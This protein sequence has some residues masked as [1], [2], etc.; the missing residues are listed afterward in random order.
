MLLSCICVSVG[1][2]VVYSVYLCV[3]LRC[4]ALIE[5][6]FDTIEATLIIHVSHENIDLLLVHIADSAVEVTKA[7]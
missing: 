4:V 3:Q 2:F 5:R 6:H 7:N 1:T